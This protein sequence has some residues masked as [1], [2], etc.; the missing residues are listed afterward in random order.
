V[1]VVAAFAIM[2]DL[3]V[4]DTASQY[5]QGLDDTASMI[6]GYTSCAPE[7]SNTGVLLEEELDKLDLGDDI[8]S[9]IP[10][11]APKTINEDDF[12]GV[13]ED[14]KD[15]GITEL[16]PHACRFVV[17]EIAPAEL[18]H[19]LNCLIYPSRNPATAAYTLLLPSSNVSFVPSGSVTLAGTPP[20]P[21][22]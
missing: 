1:A 9:S 20:H 3:D 10:P 13:L 6:S 11:S 17:I 22:L 18:T 21:T 16:P 8:T 7:T 12:D 15:D 5:G 14:V 2:D 4:Y 19:H